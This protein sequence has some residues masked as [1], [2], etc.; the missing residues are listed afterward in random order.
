VCEIK[1]ADAR[2]RVTNWTI[3]GIFL[4]LR[5]WEYWRNYF[6]ILEIIYLFVNE[7]NT[8]RIIKFVL[9]VEDSHYIFLFR[10]FFTSIAVVMDGNRIESIQWES[11][12]DFFGGKRGDVMRSIYWW[13]IH[14]N[15]WILLTQPIK[16]LHIQIYYYNEEMQTITIV[17]CKKI[18]IQKL[19][20]FKILICIT[21]CCA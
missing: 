4:R 10:F 17:L 2:P 21:F 11:E 16:F 3:P 8:N 6:T 12:T 1:T 14:H 19:Y 7:H 9:L 20:Q 13:H 5:F 15:Q 18:I